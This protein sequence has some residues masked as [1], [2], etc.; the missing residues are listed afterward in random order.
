MSSGFP[1]NDLYSKTIDEH[2]NADSSS[3]TKNFAGRWTKD[4]H[5]RFVEGL[6]IYGKNWKK[7]EDHVSSR[8]GAQIRSHAQ[9]FFNRI[10]KELYVNKGHAIDNISKI[11]DVSCDPSEEKSI[12]KRSYNDF[13]NSQGNL[14]EKLLAKG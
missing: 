3:N 7:V 1:C 8:S 6:K 12:K 14:E 10:E 4:E 5:T 13:F 2:E 9:K 11:D